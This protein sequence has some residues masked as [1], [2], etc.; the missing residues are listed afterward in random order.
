MIGIIIPVYNAEKFLNRCIDSVLNQEYREFVLILVDDGST[1]NSGAILDAYAKRDARIIVKHTANNGHASA[2]NIGLD[3]AFSLP[4]IEWITFIDSDDWVDEKYLKFLYFSASRYNSD[5]IIGNFDRVFD[6]K[7]AAIVPDC[8]SSSAYSID[9]EEFWCKD[10]ITATIPCGKLYRK[11]LFRNQ[12]YPKK[13]HD[14]EFVTYKLLF[15]NKNIVFIDLCLYHYFY[16]PNSVMASGWSPKHL[17]SIEA[18]EQRRAFFRDNGFSKA[19]ELD[20]KL[21]INEL[22][23]SIV[24]LKNYGE[25]YNPNKNLLTDNLKTELTTHGKQLGFNF[26][27]HPYIWLEAF[28]SKKNKI[29]YFTLILMNKLF[30]K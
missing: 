28:P 16:N 25:E 3:T 20:N 21:L 5:L 24:E 29:R 7:N 10:R 22:Y 18:I 6:V 23:N 1:D 15:T 17:D 26:K 4:E 13:V 2:R 11:S 9:P 14:D 12:R 27:T 30:H 8:L 19:Y